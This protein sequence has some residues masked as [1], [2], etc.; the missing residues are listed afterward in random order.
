LKNTYPIKWIGGKKLLI[1]DIL[2]LTGKAIN[3]HSIKGFV[4]VFGG[5]GKVGIGILE[6]YNINIIYNDINKILSNFFEVLRD[7][8]EELYKALKFTEYGDDTH[9][10]AFEIINH[11]IFKDRYYSKVKLAWAFFVYL[12]GTFGGFWQPH[13]YSG[14]CIDVT[15]SS[16]FQKIMYN[17][18]ESMEYFSDIIRNNFYILNKD[19]KEVLKR[20]SKHKSNLIYLDPPY[21]QSKTIKY[22]GKRIMWNKED[23]EYI[24]DYCLNTENKFILNYNPTS[25][26]LDKLKEFDIITYSKSA[27]GGRG[28]EKNIF[29]EVMIT[30]I[31]NGQMSLF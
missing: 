15:N 3:N 9:R 10:T 13:T 12:R 20:Y 29:K 8:Y 26:I 28:E 5:S 18:I 27:T 6:K 21:P 24:I 19:Y 2:N 4:D 7:N 22:N 1:P 16:S 30:N 14:L 25:D 11:H 31:K 17:A 23:E